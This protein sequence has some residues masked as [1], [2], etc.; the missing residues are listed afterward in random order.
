MTAWRFLLALTAL[1]VHPPAACSGRAC[2][3]HNPTEHRMRGWPLVWRDDR[4]LFERICPHSCG[5]PDPDQRDYWREAG[6]EWQGT[7]GCDGCCRA[8]KAT[9]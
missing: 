6:Q 4:G 1:N 9:L 5:H 3:V 7:H 2:T 8:G